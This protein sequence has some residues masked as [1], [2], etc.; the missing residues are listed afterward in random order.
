MASRFVGY[1]PWYGELPNNR[2][3]ALVATDT[4]VA[5][6]YGLNNAQGRGVTF[7]E[8]GTQVY[9]GMIVGL[10]KYPQDIIVNVC[11]EKQLTN[12]RAASADIAVRLS[13]AVEMS[14][15]E[16]LDFIADD[17]LLEVTPK[18]LRLRKKLRTQHDRL[19]AKVRA[20]A[21]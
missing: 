18:T 12:I 11:K 19:R 21:G 1:V 16:A 15:E 5:T 8:P 13:P 4:G 14:L 10:S 17:E 20:A 6:T 9:E 3:G 7:V 2:N